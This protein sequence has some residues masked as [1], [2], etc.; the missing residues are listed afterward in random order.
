MATF[1]N[2]LYDS[3]RDW[4]DVAHLHTPGQILLSFPVRDYNDEVAETVRTW[5]QGEDEN[6]R[7]FACMCR[8][9]CC[10]WKPDITGD[11]ILK[12]FSAT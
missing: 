5:L 8:S 1:R 4:W 9:L 11:A 2:V 10:R 7:D 12:L 3:A 6:I